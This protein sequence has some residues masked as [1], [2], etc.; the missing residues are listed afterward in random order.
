MLA[1]TSPHAQHFA[2]IILRDDSPTAADHDPVAILWRSQTVEQLDP[3]GQM[4]MS[5]ER[6][7]IKRH[8]VPQ[9]QHC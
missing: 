2:H 5:Q 6:R 3:G 8:R 9:E 4:G 1:C 7:L